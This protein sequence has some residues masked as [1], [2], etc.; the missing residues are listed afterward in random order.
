MN[1]TIEAWTG[2][3]GQ[4][5][6]ERNRPTKDQMRARADMFDRIFRGIGH[7]INVLEVGCNIGQNLVA[8]RKLYE[9]HGFYVNL[10]GIEPNQDAL[11]E[12]QKTFPGDKIIK[13]SAENIPFRRNSFDLVF[14]SGVLIHIYPYNLY[15]VCK[16]IHRVSSRYILSIEYFSADPEE[17]E[18]R[19]ESG[20]LWK[21]DFGKYWIEEFG[22]R[23]VDVGFFWKETT[24]LDNL[25][26][27]L[28][29]K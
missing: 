24:G 27:V 16:E 23:P 11:D 13:A 28:L 1:R 17:K 29:E 10:N 4:S 8:I 9:D 5:Y 7:P 2:Q 26:W 12:C 19:G 15:E 3:F 20:L 22:M 25:T 21:R 6:T 18:Y 14:T